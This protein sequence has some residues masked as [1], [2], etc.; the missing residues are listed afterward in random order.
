MRLEAGNFLGGFT[1]PESPT[2]WMGRGRPGSGLPHR[3]SIE[4]YY[5]RMSRCYSGRLSDGNQQSN[6]RNRVTKNR[7]YPSYESA[8]VV[9]QIS[10]CARRRVR[11]RS[12]I[13]WILQVLGTVD[14]VRL[15][16]GIRPPRD[17]RRQRWKKKKGCPSGV[18]A[19]P[20]LNA[21]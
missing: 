20:Y 7:P 1:R 4:A 14:K 16:D 9:I 5:S 8:M 6:G 15:Q 18:G 19:K 21:P 2:M 11:C 12:E 17:W 10:V 3:E 13:R